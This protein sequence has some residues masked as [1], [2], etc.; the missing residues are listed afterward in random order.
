M[1]TGRP[2][3]VQ[4]LNSYVACSKWT[5]TGKLAFPLNA[6]GITG[7]HQADCSRFANLELSSASVGLPKELQVPLC[8]LPCKAD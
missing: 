1:A 8:R 2:T 6:A 5:G 7:K 4:K 3:R